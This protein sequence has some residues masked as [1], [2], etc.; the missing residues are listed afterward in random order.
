MTHSEQ[1]Y[2][3]DANVLINAWNQYYHQD[4]CPD[5]W[6]ELRRFGLAGRIFLPEIV[7]EEIV[8]ADDSLADWVKGSGIPVYPIEGS[9]TAIVAKIYKKDARH[10]Q[11]VDATKQRSIADPWVIA[12]AIEQ[13]AC[14]VTKE[15]K[16]TQTDR[17]VKIPNVCDNMGVKWINDFQMIR[18]LG[19]HFSC[20]V[21]PQSSRSA[22]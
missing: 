13:N 20:T 18:E 14:V 9:T 17:R 21:R 16:E 4:F 7:K 8:R 22:V 10:Q 11:L 2:C 19:L 5:Y 15:H 1:R 6:K 12:H 3:I